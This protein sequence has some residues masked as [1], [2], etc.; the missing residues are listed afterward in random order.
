MAVFDGLHKTT[1]K[2]GWENPD[3]AFSYGIT[4]AKPQ[5]YLAPALLSLLSGLAVRLVGK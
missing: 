5:R 1:S 4:V 2:R 3:L